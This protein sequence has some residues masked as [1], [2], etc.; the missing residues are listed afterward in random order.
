M[1]YDEGLAERVREALADVAA[2]DEKRMFGGIAF[3]V[4]GHMACGVT[5]ERFMVRV[6]PEGYAA[7]LAAPHAREMDFTGRPLKGFVFVDA[8]GYAS[9]EDLAGWIE[10]SLTFVRSLPPK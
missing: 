6:G 1:A 5:G 10:Q 3:M 9:D 2:V 8:D 7:A 4:N